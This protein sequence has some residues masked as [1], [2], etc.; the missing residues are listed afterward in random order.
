MPI[1]EFDK[2]AGGTPEYRTGNDGELAFGVPIHGKRIIVE[3]YDLV[4]YPIHDYN[5]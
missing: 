5:E 2:Q 4:P 1:Y 3:N